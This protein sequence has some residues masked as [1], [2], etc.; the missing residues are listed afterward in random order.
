MFKRADSPKVKSNDDVS[1][2]IVSIDS[3]EFSPRWIM[4]LCPYFFPNVQIPLT[5]I[6]DPF[7]NLNR[8]YP[9]QEKEE[10]ARSI[11]IFSQNR[12]VIDKAD[13]PKRIKSISLK[14]P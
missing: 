10:S 12:I 9:K 2:V 14:R 13:A 3:S 11:S 4:P 1:D 6:F 8:H 7:F 5:L